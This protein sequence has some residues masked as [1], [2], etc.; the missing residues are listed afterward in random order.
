M[1]VE[2]GSAV[3]KIE[4][5]S[6]GVQSGID[7]ARRSLQGA[8]SSLASLGGSATRAGAGLMGL[9]APLVGF[10]AAAAK[11]AGDFEG[12]MNVLAVAAKGGST[13]LEDLRSVAI[14]AGSDVKLVGVSASDVAG[15]MTN[16]S[17]AGLDTNAMLGNM[18]G[19]LGGTAEL[20]G[21]LRAAIDLAA[22]SE[23]DLDQASQLV[24]TTMSTFGL[25]A[26]EAVG[27]MNNY[28]QSADA[29]V[30]SV[31]DLGAAMANLGPTMAQFGF[32]LEDVNNALA[33]LSTRG[34]TGAEA[35]TALK[36][37][38]TNMIRGTK[39]V[40]AAL[41][42]LN[43]SLYDSQGN[44]RE[45]PDILAQLEA[46]MAGLTEEQ[47]NAATQTIFGTYGMKAAN[48][49]L[50]EG[51]A[52]WNKM[53][54]AVAGGASMQE[55]AAA[56]TQGF[57][58]S[59]EQ[60]KDS[61]QTFLIE[62][63]T[64]LI[65][66]VLTPLVRILTDVFG[67]LKDVN[68]EFI[69]IAVV[70]GGVITALGGVLLV[71]GQVAG[72]I[73]AIG[74]LFGAGG[75]LA[76]IGA[77][78]GAAFAAIAP[79]ILPIIAI[80]AAVVLAVIALKAAWENNFLGIRDIMQQVGQAIKAVFDFIKG[81]FGAFG[82][83]LKGE[84]TW[85]QFVAKVK[86]SF[87][88]LKNFLKNIFGNIGEQVE[89]GPIKRLGEAISRIWDGL[90]KNLG[91]I[92]QFIDGVKNIFVGLIDFFR[93]LGGRIRDTIGNIWQLIT[94][95]ISPQE[96]VSKMS[97]D[98]ASFPD[99]LG[100]IWDKIRTGVEE[101]WNGIKAAIGDGP[102]G[103]QAGRD[104]EAGGVPGTHL[105]G[106]RPGEGEGHGGVRE[107]AG[108]PGKCVGADQDGGGGGLGVHQGADRRGGRDRA[109]HPGRPDRVPVGRLCGHVGS[110]QGGGNAGLGADQGGHPECRGGDCTPI[111]G[112]LGADQGRGGDEG[113]G[114]LGGD[115]GEV[116]GNP[117][118]HRDEGPG[119]LDG[120]DDEVGGNPDGYHHEGAGDLDGDRHE[121]GRNPDGHR[122][123]GAGNLDRDHHE[124]GGN[125][126]RDRDEGAGDLGDD[127]GEV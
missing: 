6:S 94:G 118:D 123:E 107:R 69:K 33:I 125:P 60:L 89:N 52:G 58:A 121:M 1:G 27:A 18:Q 81:V 87:E 113:A 70:V 120:R 117:D 5:D 31:S 119:N 29:S 54:D 108:V 20:G 43:V 124:V 114:D 48:T 9:G 79:V 45:M 77:A 40:D 97:A 84:I 15:A 13:S 42:D 76:G 90:M 102:R 110:D 30:A 61:I 49:L 109:G 2:L 36:S 59:M 41:K 80:I 101:A 50:S 11:V 22:A 3:G 37:M 100:K 93:E 47:R 62:V 10:G 88:N 24:V 75:V 116:G 115:Q 112:G 126:D 4:I 17:K 14:Q 12:Q 99:A 34:I 25:S 82:Q 46:G 72:A 63:G 78:V 74:A 53:K 57:N 38:F 106:R 83:F 16:F 91:P 7:A 103:D 65:R 55:T 98:W 86:Q 95:K 28:V 56:R 26:D 19:Y 96:F 85:D 104:P 71:F 39:E 105:R 23:L 32:P 73:S 35:G 111:G 64:P 92:G 127:H 8:E 67:R 68:P 21:A 44:M 66:D 51:A 122:D